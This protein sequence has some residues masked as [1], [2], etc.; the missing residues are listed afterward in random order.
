MPW[1]ARRIGETPARRGA[2]VRVSAVSIRTGSDTDG[3]GTCNGSRQEDHAMSET[4]TCQHANCGCDPLDD[5]VF[6]GTYCANAAG[7][8]LPGEA[9]LEGTCACGH[10]ACKSAEAPRP[11]GPQITT[12]VGRAEGR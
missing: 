7:E 6:C 2:A 3:N 5:V 4:E 12:S 9:D 1:G 11:V 10:A 8:S